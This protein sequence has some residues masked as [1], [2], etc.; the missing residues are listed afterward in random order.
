MEERKRTKAQQKL[1]EQ[2]GEHIFL[3]QQRFV[4]EAAQLFPMPRAPAPSDA[5]RGQAAAFPLAST[6][7]RA[8]GAQIMATD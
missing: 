3:L 2:I 6:A 1:Y 8:P 4:C 5:P 7:V